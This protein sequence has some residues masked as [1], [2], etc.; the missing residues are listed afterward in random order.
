MARINISV[1]DDLY[2]LATKWRGRVNLSE[3]CARALRG[4][5]EAA[6]SHR[7]L[8][9]LLVSL[10]PSTRLEQTL[11]GRFGLSDVRVADDGVDAGEL[12]EEI[13]VCAAQ[14]LDEHLVE[15]AV[16][17]IGGGRQMWCLVR[18][19]RPRQLGMLIV[20][21]GVRQNDPRLLHAH[22]N[23]LVTLLWLLYRPYADARLVGSEA[24]GLF[25]LSSTKSTQPRYFVVGSCSSF[26][27]RGPLAELLG[28]DTVSELVRQEAQSEFLYQF[29]NTSRNMVPTSF[30][31]DHSVLSGPFLQGLSARSDAR[32]ILA[33]GGREKWKSIRDVLNLRLCNVLI[34]DS[35][36]AAHLLEER[37]EAA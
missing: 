37:L 27:S 32:V 6:E 16:L 3:I 36:T 28:H 17:A 8:G 22:P 15:G 10:R 7:N 21:L 19:I 18:E 20:G 31:H 33:A 26:D 2:G 13:G 25:K 4:E 23:T 14:Y 24:E 1:P 35:K 12:R 34:T 29:I 11:K 30:A 5:L 9:S